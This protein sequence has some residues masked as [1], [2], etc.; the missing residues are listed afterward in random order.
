MTA[1]DDLRAALVE[2]EAAAT[3]EREHDKGIF[4]DG[5]VEGLSAAVRIAE[6][7]AGRDES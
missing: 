3:A 4:R 2:A 5:I 1:L 7:W 6:R